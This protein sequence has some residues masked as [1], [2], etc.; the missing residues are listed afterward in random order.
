M[1]K[2]LNTQPPRHLL[3]RHPNLKLIRPP[4]EGGVGAAS[5]VLKSCWVTSH[6]VAPHQ[7]P[8]VPQAEPQA[9]DGGG[10]GGK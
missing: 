1:A 6:T 7:V 4:L 5:A 8:A 9:L 10:G 2:Q 3:P